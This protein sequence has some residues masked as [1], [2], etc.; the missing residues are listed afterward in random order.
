M[1]AHL[2]GV[3]VLNVAVFFECV[4]QSASVGFVVGLERVQA[5]IGSKDLPCA[6]HAGRGVN[7]SPVGG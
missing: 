6:E 4:V 3:L 5:V 2:E 7:E 1:W